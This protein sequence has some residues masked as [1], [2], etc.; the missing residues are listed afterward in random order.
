MG[1][2]SQ[3]PNAHTIFGLYSIILTLSWIFLLMGPL[4]LTVGKIVTFTGGLVLEGN[5]SILE[6]PPNLIELWVSIESH[7]S[8]ACL[9]R[10]NSVSSA[11]PI[12]LSD[13]FPLVSSVRT[14]TCFRSKKSSLSLK[15]T[16]CG[17]RLLLQNS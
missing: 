16:M 14:L 15:R 4:S 6:G 7:R 11:T 13:V 9:C 17:M 12:I 10:R 2:T 3:V 1:H 8:A 5:V